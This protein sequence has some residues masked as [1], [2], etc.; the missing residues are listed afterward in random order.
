MSNSTDFLDEAPQVKKI[1]SGLNTISI[2]N[3]V[4]IGLGI[5]GIAFMPM[6]CKMMDTLENSPGMTPEKFEGVVKLCDNLGIIIGVSIIGVI[7]Q[8]VGIVLMRKLKLNGL[9]IFIAATAV[10]FL[11]Q[12]VLLGSQYFTKDTST[13]AMSLVSLLLFPILYFTQ[14]KHLS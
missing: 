4:L 9:W 3:Y 5:L 7:G 13:L 11:V 8:I 6:M 10:P 2:I 1:P 12:L 14:K